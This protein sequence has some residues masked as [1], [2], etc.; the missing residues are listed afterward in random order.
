MVFRFRDKV[1]KILGMEGFGWKTERERERKEYT[2]G[3]LF[4]EV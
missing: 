4:L 3:F 2:G 1:L